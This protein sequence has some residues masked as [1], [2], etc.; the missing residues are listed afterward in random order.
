MPTVRGDA[1]FVG[2]ADLFAD[3]LRPLGRSA[4]QR[5]LVDDA[6]AGRADLA[7]DLVRNTSALTEH[8]RRDRGVA[9]CFRGGHSGHFS[10][11]SEGVGCCIPLIR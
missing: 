8:V 4:T 7:L 3:G 10:E 1:D 2:V 5:T 11:G 9:M 6:P